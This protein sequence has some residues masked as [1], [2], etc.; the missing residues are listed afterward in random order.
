MLLVV[1]PDKSNSG[2]FAAGIDLDDDGLSYHF[3]W[4]FKPDGKR[5]EPVDAG[6]SL[7]KQDACSCW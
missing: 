6:A 5:R 4:L 7:F 1:M 2:G 3:G